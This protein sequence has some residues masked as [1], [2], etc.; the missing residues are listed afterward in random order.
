MTGLVTH[1]EGSAKPLAGAA[2]FVATY[3]AAA[4]ILC[5]PLEFTSVWLHQ[6]LSRFV[7]VLVGLAFGYLVV[8]RRRSIRVPRNPSVWFLVLYTVVSLASWLGS[9]ATGSLNAVADIALYP[10]V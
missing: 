2:E 8:S 10:F 4:Y 1:S 3:G 5:L 6:Q 7:L 9:R